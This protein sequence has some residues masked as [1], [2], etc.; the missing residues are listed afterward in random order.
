MT[1]LSHVPVERIEA[2]IRFIRDEKVILDR[3]LA[4]LYGVSTSNLNKAV[5]R[6]LNRFPDDFM[7][8]LT[9]DEFDALRFQIGTSKRG[10]PRYRPYAFTEHGALMAASVLNSAIAIDTSVQVIRA[11]VKIRALVAS[12]VELAGEIEALEKKYDHHFKIVFDAIR[13]L[14]TPP[15]PKR[16]LIGFRKKNK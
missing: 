14:M 7:F 12:H 3:D 5:K 11:F 8:Q 15:K 16:K 1:T 2:L 10:G 6:N 13:Q 4:D 9:Q